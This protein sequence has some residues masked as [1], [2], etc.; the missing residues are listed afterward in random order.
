MQQKKTL[1]LVMSKLLKILSTIIV[2]VVETEKSAC[3]VHPT[4]LKSSFI[5]HFEAPVC[6]NILG[7]H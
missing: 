3:N 6:I 4:S 2:K 7:N 5:S 1:I